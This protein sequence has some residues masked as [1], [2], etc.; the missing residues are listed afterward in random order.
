[1]DRYLVPTIVFGALVGSAFILG[2]GILCSVFD[3]AYLGLPLGPP[4]S[5]GTGFDDL[6]REIG[7]KSGSGSIA[8]RR[9]YA[10]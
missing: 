10:G 5:A 6:N 1:M 2:L 4:E 8:E 7:Q 9:S 3:L